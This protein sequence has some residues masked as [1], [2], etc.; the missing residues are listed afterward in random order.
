MVNKLKGKL[1]FFLVFFFTSSVAQNASRPV[2]NQLAED[3]LVKPVSSKAEIIYNETKKEITL[4]NGLLNRK[5]R[6][7]PN[8]V[9][10]DYKNNI[11]GQQL[12]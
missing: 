1:L 6:I 5:F 10:I 11:T 9:C 12:L 3:W 7:F 8:V 4:S 2:N